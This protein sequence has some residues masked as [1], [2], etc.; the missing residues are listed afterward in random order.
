MRPKICR[1]SKGRGASE[2]GRTPLDRDRTP[3]KSAQRNQ[4]SIG[5]E[6]LRGSEP[7]RRKEQTHVPNRGV[8]EGGKLPRGDPHQGHRIFQTRR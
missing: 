2:G 1:R 6:G 4:T 3:C 8:G 5:R 7:N